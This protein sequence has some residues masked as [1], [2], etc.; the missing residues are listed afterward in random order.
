MRGSPVWLASISRRAVLADK[1]LAVGL[2]SKQTIE[3]STALLKRALAGV[4]DETRERCFRMNITLCLHRALT[5]AEV[6]ALPD[7]FHTAPALDLAGG[8]VEVLWE[9]EEG[10]ET[11]RPCH[12]PERMSLWPGD[13]LL[14]FPQDCGWCPPCQA[15][16]ALENERLLAVREA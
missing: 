4:G 13:P 12:A 2:W 8:P 9:T 10:W 3:E 5:P 11:T 16:R 7:W 15:R 14:W 1:P 6:N